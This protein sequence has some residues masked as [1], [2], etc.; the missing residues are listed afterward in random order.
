MQGKDPVSGISE[1]LWSVV[2]TVFGLTLVVH[3]TWV[4]LQPLLPVIAVVTAVGL[5]L[6]VVRGYYRSR[7]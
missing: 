7:W 4:L 2:L 3:I 1:R 5:V 6:A